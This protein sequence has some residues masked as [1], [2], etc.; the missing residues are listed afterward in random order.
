MCVYIK[1][2]RRSSKILLKGLKPICHK[3]LK[4][5]EAVFEAMV[6]TEVALM[7]KH[8]NVNHV[9]EP[10]ACDRRKQS[11]GERDVG[12]DGNMAGRC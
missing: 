12:S 9:I 1:K 3:S 5:I 7:G 2:L 4:K 8:N 10:M 11:E 6:V